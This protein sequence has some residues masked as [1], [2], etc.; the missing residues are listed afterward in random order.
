MD[1]KSKKEEIQDCIQTNEAFKYEKI[2]QEYLL[3]L[4]LFISSLENF[5]PFSSD[6]K[7]NKRKM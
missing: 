6:F 5:S 2:L 3:R 1:Q 7:T 4:N